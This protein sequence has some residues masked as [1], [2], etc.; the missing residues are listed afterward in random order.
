MDL[1]LRTLG[2]GKQYRLFHTDRAMTLQSAFL[3][4]FRNIKP[5]GK[6]WALRDLNI[7][8]KEG[9][10]LGIIGRNG[11]GKSTLLRLISGVIKP[12]AGKIEIRGKIGGLLS[13]GAGFHPDLTGRENALINGVLLGMTRSEVLEQM[14]DIFRFAELEHVI[15]DPLRVY[16]TGMGMRL[17]FSVIAHTN[18]DILLI[19][20]VLA[21]G[22][23]D[24][25]HKSFERIRQFKAAHCTILLVS[26]DLGAINAIC[27]ELLWLDAGRCV[28]YGEVS[29]V[30]AAYMNEQS[31]TADLE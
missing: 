7:E 24:F 15:D 10:A 17:G 22:D 5:K 18:P 31:K 8:L 1:A 4:G 27:D 26:H 6:F 21:V 3:N 14:E 25:Q 30:T 2:L 9:K 20:E 13:V 19:D 29:E 11:A 28:M 23:R 16:S 12:D